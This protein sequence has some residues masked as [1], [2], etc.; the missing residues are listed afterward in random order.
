VVVLRIR[1]E[2][3]P[4]HYATLCYL[5]FP[6]L[7][8]Y[9]DDSSVLNILFPHKISPFAKFIITYPDEIFLANNSLSEIIDTPLFHAIVKFKWRTFARSRFLFIFFFY[10]AF[11][12]FFTASIVTNYMSLRIIST[13]M[14]TFQSLCVFRYGIIMYLNGVGGRFFTPTTFLTLAVIVFPAIIAFMGI[15]IEANDS[16]LIL[17]RAITMCFLWIGAIEFLVAFKRIGIFIIGKIF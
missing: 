12:A 6:G 17:L 16:L 4:Q 14:G 8:S 3:I 5:P 9:P 10:L 7:F 13:I 2:T 11:F 15:F 1:F